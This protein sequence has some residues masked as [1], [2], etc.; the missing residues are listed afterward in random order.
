MSGMP[1]ATRLENRL[2]GTTYVQQRLEIANPLMSNFEIKHRLEKIFQEDLLVSV[3]NFS[4]T[5]LLGLVAYVSEISANCHATKLENDLGGTT[6]NR[7]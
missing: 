2:G 7:G 5:Y 4:F 1:H 6:Y 3:L